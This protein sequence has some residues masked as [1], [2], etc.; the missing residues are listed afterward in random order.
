M[1]PPTRP[2]GGICPAAS[3]SVPANT[4]Q[5]FNYTITNLFKN[6][7]FT[8]NASPWA[9]LGTSAWSSTGGVGNGPCL[10]LAG[11]KYAAYYYAPGQLSTDAHAAM[12]MSFSASANIAGAQLSCSY[13]CLDANGNGISGLVGSAGLQTLT[14]TMSNYTF[15]FNVPNDPRVKFIEPILY[16]ARYDTVPTDVIYL[17]NRS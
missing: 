12:V 10:K 9:L 17:D 7:A 4:H 11:A 14:T 3:A 6:S 2:A 16:I 8:T 15:Q 5:V 1:R 13:Y